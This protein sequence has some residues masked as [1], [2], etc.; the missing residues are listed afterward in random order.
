MRTLKWKVCGM[1]ENQNIAEVAALEPDFLG[2]IFYES[3]PRYVGKAFKLPLEITG[4]GKRVGVFVN[5]SVEEIKIAYST[6]SLDYVQLH[7]HESP[8][9]VEQ[10]KK[11][12]MH[13]IKAFGVDEH[14][15]FEKL[16]PYSA[17]VDMFLFDTK[18]KQYGG[19]GMRFSWELLRNYKGSVPFLLSGG[20]RPE[21]ME[22]VLKI[23]HPQL[24]GIDVNSGVELRPG[25]KDIEKVTYI[26][27]A[28]DANHH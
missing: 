25:F 16:E 11:L 23:D 21:H 10:I 4:N 12:N 27:Q 17:W 1:R 3:S 2:F 5:A 6:H 9:E 8:A 22:E 13:V 28:L 24:R 26:K 19:T 18:S 14:F 7:G 15:D 20:I